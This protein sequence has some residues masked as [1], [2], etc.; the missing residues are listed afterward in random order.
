MNCE[1]VLILSIYHDPEPIAKAGELAREL[2]RRV[3]V[4]P[5][6]LELEAMAAPRYGVGP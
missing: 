2:E 1:P 3:R 4:A 6:M 5:T